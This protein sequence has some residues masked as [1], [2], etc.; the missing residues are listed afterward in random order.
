MMNTKRLRSAHLLTAFFLTGLCLSSGCK[1]QASKSTNLPVANLGSPV[2]V[3]SGDSD[4]AEPA[5]A[6]SA[7]GSVYVVWVEHHGKEA[8]VMLNHVSGQG[9]V[10]GATVRVNPLA[11]QATAWR[12]D[13]PTV[14]VA[15][16][17]TVFVGWT[18]RVE[19]EAG[20]ATDINLSASHDRGQT[21]SAPVKINDDPKPVDHGLHA[22]AIA[23]DGRIYVS[24]LD[25]R[26]VV[27]V[28]MK[29]MKMDGASK[30]A[31]AESNREVFMASSNDG[32][33]TF[34]VN[35]KVATNACP[36]C[37]VA[38]A[39]SSDGRL[40]VSWRQVLPGDFRH[41]AV[42]SSTDHGKIFSSPVI[43]SDDRWMLT[44]CPVSGATLSIAT[45]GALQVLWYSEG[46]NGQTGLYWSVSRDHGAS[47]G[48]RQLLAAGTV[49]GTPVLMGDAKI[50]TAV[51]QD[52]GRDNEGV[53][54]AEDFSGAAAPVR[55]VAT[56][57]R[58]PAGATNGERVFVA[59]IAKG[60]KGQDIW[61]VTV[62]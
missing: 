4:A 19:F 36:C 26:N 12:G 46:Q 21:F 29:D 22:L 24:W 14:A 45:D 23:N 28:P 60:A 55:L 30:S 5:M 57:G 37:K 48:P 54:M 27:E 49:S 39:T 58:L 44:G 8:D 33:R 42:A 16:D 56:N 31:H 32:G 41:I 38:V 43:V 13:P 6:V 62:G 35:Q 7:D 15:P 2:R 17:Q 25:S 1:K 40:Y 11:G 3:S 61:L 9:K 34:S 51:W 53:M 52:A 20:H 59:Y 50:L 47:F 18:A 10:L